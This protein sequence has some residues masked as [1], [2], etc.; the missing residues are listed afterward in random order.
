MYDRTL[1]INITLNNKRI[2][3]VT[4]RIEISYF[5]VIIYILIEL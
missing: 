2:E 4:I 3:D 5:K 1:K